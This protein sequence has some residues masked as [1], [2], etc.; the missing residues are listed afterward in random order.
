MKDP[1]VL[2]LTAIQFG[3]V[4]GSYGI[5]IW[6]PTILKSHG[7]TVSAI[8]LVSSVPYIFATLAMLTWARHVDRSGKKVLNLLLTCLLGAAGMVGAALLHTFWPALVGIT[9]AVIGVTTA[10]AVFWSIPTRFLTGAAAAGGFA[11][12]NSVGTFGGFAGPLMMGWLKDL[13]GSF[14]AG[15]LGMAAMLLI[16]TLLTGSLKYFVKD[17]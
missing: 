4:M 15:I 1:R 3:F 13:T 8:S 14:S 6:L 11:F 5:G 16:S 12:I 9:V 10:R 17:E 7:L 2:I